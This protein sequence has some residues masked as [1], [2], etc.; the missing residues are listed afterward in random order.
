MRGMDLDD[1]RLT[2]IR[3]DVLQKKIF[4]QEIYA[5]WYE[6]IEKNLGDAKSKIIELGSGSGFLE[7]TLPQII[8]TD[9]FPQP[10]IHLVMDGLRIPFPPKSL[11]AIVLVDVFHHLPDVE[12]FLN[13][14]TRTL[15][16]E[17]ELL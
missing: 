17:G 16:K 9:V 12:E 1:P 7:K 8:K 5:E 11:D 13:E 6:L 14:A 2:N 15:K 3:H 10:H 4:L